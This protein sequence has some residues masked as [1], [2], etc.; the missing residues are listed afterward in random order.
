M[1]RS[2]LQLSLLAGLLASALTG[3]SSLPFGSSA[4]LSGVATSQAA[5][6]NADIT[7]CDA[8]GIKK[9]A[10]TDA[11]G[12]YKLDID[13]MKAPLLVAVT[14]APLAT[15]NKVPQPINGNVLYTALLPTLTDNN[16]ANINPLTDKIASDVVTSK[17]VGLKGSVQL[18]NACAT[19]IS[20]KVA[21]AAIKAKTDELRGLFVDALKANKVADADKFDPVTSPMQ[22]GVAAVL[23]TIS[24]NRDGWG[25]GSDDQLRGTNLFDRNVQEISTKNVKL[26]PA[27]KPWSSYKTRIFVVGDSTASNYGK[28][29][30]PRM[31]W[32]QPFDRQLKAGSDVKVV[33]LAQ[34]GRASRSFISEGWFKVLADNL[35][36]GDFVLMQWGHNDEKC[37]VTGSLDWVN[38]C[39]YANGADGK[40]RM[41]TSKL[42]MLPPGV[43]AEDTSFQKSLEKFISLAKSKGATIAL[44]TPTTRVVQDKEVKG[45]EE[46]AFPITKST[47]ITSKGDF[48][49]D[50]SQTI[51]DTA[52]AN[53]VALIDLD[54]KTIA[55]ANSVALGTGGEDA[56]GGWRDYWLGVKDFA[57]YPFYK[58]AKTTGHYKKADRTHF[59]EKGAVKVGELIVEGIKQDQTGTLAELIKLLK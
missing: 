7:V 58:E 40:P 5:L 49:G 2:P 15:I 43:K 53:G 31:G 3:C 30:A 59:Q 8:T 29:V 24:H 26:D 46:G 4:T 6:A 10:K 21:P 50:Y 47:H 9:T 23:A 33:N 57:K 36:K 51:R 48:P 39:V 55:F 42:D 20:A 27:L 13:G 16:T 32:G 22:A 52:K 25:S 45:Y 18:F 54:A 1:K 41:A 34:S 28:D 12:A 19:G 37:D 44:I 38:R 17:D 11:Q 14:N 56:T 35:Q